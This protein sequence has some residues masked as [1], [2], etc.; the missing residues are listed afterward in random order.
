MERRKDSKGKVLKEGESQRKDGRYQY[1]WI[2]ASGKRR[3]IYAT[4]LSELRE[5][6][7]DAKD[8]EK[9]GISV[10]SQ[11]VTVEILLNRYMEV[12]KASLK[13][14]S[15]KNL[16]TN[17]NMI[18]PFSFYK[19]PISQI[20]SSDAKLFMK[21]LHDNGYRYGTVTNIKALLRP[22]F[23]FACDDG[24]ILKNPFI[25]SLSKIIP[26]D[27]Q[28]KRILSE[29]QYRR[30]IAFC[31]SDNLLA[32]YVDEI[33]ILYETGLR[34]GEFC[35]ITMKDLD[36]DKGIVNIDHQLVVIDR[37]KS[38]QTPK[39]KKGVR[40]VPLSE[41]AKKAFA[42][43]IMYRPRLDEKDE[44]II[45]GYSGF[46]QII[47]RTRSPRV[48]TSV[49]ANLKRSIMEYNKANPEDQLP[50][51]TPHSLRHMFCTRMVRIGMNVKN[52]QYLMGHNDIG[53]TLNVYSHTD[54]EEAMQ[55]F[56]LLQNSQNVKP[57]A[58]QASF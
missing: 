41:E 25:F 30:F 54:A 19:K 22:A 50:I 48:A 36:L 51:I 35:G 14:T 13:P 53:M 39:T 15:V 40:V 9:N 4:T 43:L 1:R 29:E 57:P 6:K 12:H 8:L 38:I 44:P 55:N 26:K 21:Q 32:R 56:I 28:E 24:L 3:T 5:K 49:A 2:D 23:A 17:I 58:D 7:E 33:I 45:D 34:V 37:V 11:S 10:D 20:S 31:R 27:E 18:K 46:V 52:V 47:N 16:N 42:Q